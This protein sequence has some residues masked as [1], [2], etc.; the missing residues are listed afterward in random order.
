[1]ESPGSH[2]ELSGPLAVAV[3]YFTWPTLVWPDCRADSR[4]ALPRHRFNAHVTAVL[5]KLWHTP[6]QEQGFACLRA[7][8]P[9]CT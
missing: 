3:L 5:S 1:M 8:R 6:F 7:E 2:T 9:L 4:E